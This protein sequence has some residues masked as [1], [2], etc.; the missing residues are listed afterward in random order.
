MSR[1][2]QKGNRFRVAEI[3]SASLGGLTN[4]YWGTAASCLNNMGRPELLGS[5]ALALPAP[6]RLARFVMGR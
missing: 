6:A 2:R 3:S 5:S 4:N 1:P